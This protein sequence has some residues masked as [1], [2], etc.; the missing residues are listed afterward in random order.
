MGSKPS[1]RIPVPLTL[2]TQ[3][4]LTLSCVCMTSSLDGRPLA[5]AGIVI[6]G[7]KAVNIYTSSQTGSI[8]V[9]LLPNMPKDK[10]ACA[11]APLEAYNR[12]LTTLLLLLAIPSAG[13]RSP[14]LHLGEGDRNAL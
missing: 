6:T 12:T 8:I 10:E 3:T 9:K 1:T 4:M 11:K 14:R 7:D 13:Y 5:A 2:I